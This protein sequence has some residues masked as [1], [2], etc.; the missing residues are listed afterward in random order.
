MRNVCSIARN[1]TDCQIAGPQ[2][3]EPFDVS[4]SSGGASNRRTPPLGI[5]EPG[6]IMH[7][8][9]RS[10]SEAK[11]QAVKNLGCHTVFSGR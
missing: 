8:A 1:S 11:L 6:E 4:T 2:F 10:V 3:R 7:P 5:P 9:E